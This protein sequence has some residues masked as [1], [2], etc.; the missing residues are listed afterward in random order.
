MNRTF[1]PLEFLVRI[2][3]TEMEQREDIKK[4]L[5]VLQKKLED[6]NLK[7]EDLF[8]AICNELM[9]E[10]PSVK[11][12]CGHELCPDCFEKSKVFSE[13]QHFNITN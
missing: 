7:V 12:P 8:C 9:I 11:L 1:S 2:W 5:N 4:E 10:N 13:C 6:N 3:E